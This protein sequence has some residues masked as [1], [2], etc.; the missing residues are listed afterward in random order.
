MSPWRTAHHGP[1]VSKQAS[2]VSSGSS[3][4]SI[5]DPAEG[6]TSSSMKSGTFSTS[7]ALSSMTPFSEEP[8]RAQTG[9]VLPVTSVTVVTRPDLE[10]ATRRE[11]QE[12]NKVLALAW[13][14]GMLPGVLAG[15][16]LT[17]SLWS[18]GT[19]ITKTTEGSPKS[20]VATSSTQSHTALPPPLSATT[21]AP[22][23]SRSPVPT[24]PTVSTPTTKLTV[25]IRPTPPTRPM[26]S[27]TSS[28][29]PT[30]PTRH[31]VTTRST[32]PTT[33][34]PQ[35]TV[36][37]ATF[38]PG[39]PRLASE[40]LN[41]TLTW[42][43]SPCADFFGFV[44]SHFVGPYTNVLSTAEEFLKSASKSLLF[45]IRVPPRNQ[46]ALEKAAGLFQACIQ[47][48]NNAT[49][50]EAAA[51]RSFLRPAR[52]DMSS[53]A[54]DPKFS[55]LEAMMQL[56]MEFGFPCLVC[57]GV[58]RTAYQPKKELEFV[59]TMV[60]SQ[61]QIHEE[62]EKWI[63][64]THQ[65]HSKTGG[66][67]KHYE[68]YLKF[69]DP[70]L[71][72]ANLTT[73]IIAA[74]KE[75]GAFLEL[76]RAN[77]KVSGKGVQISNLGT[78]TEPHVTKADWFR[79][80][81][82]FTNNFY[83]G[84]DEVILW[85]NATSVVVFLTDTSRFNREDTR[86]LLAWTVLRK[87]VVYTSAVAMKRLQEAPVEDFCM[88]TVSGVLD[89]AV[90]S[91][92]VSTYT[93]RRAFQ[94]A[95]TLALNMIK[96]LQYKMTHTPWIVP[97]VQN[98]TLKKARSMR[99]VMGY[100]KHLENTT[101]L[102]KFYATFPD[103]GP[104]FVTPYL[105]MHRHLT[106]Q[107]FSN[108]ETENFTTGHANAFYSAGQNSMTI[109]GGI[110]QPP[111]YFPDGTAALNYGG[112]GQVIGHEIMHAY[113]IDGI[114]YDDTAHSVK[115]GNTSTMREYERKVLC[116]RSSYEAA[117]R[118]ARQLTDATDSEGF[119]DY[120]GIQLAYAAYRS[121]PAAERDATLPDVNL[122][123]EQT[124]FVA[125]CLKWCDLIK[126]RKPGGRY[127]PGRSRCIVPLQNMP[128]FA[129]A[130]GCKAGDL[131]NPSKRCDFW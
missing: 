58:I 50:S 115:F 29:R 38:Y 34:V 25:P 37:R 92:Y 96:A 12:R 79:L 16:A 127:W 62:D 104:G 117:E 71:N 14:W 124:F 68:K 27:T 35:P 113:D 53:M 11:R 3:T 10:E 83:V 8:S 129:H 85:D 30:A 40:Y 57:F 75:F 110:V 60:L 97:P 59:D 78:Y 23:T 63:K 49:G 13:V 64:E 128:E 2:P 65:S 28:T 118:R 105:E 98:V 70:K 103:A 9:S 45:T 112:L 42:T 39:G 126:K 84:S 66:L 18:A 88:K 61:M 119:A 111:M 26:V 102:E 54:P 47:L 46:N 20:P 100:P 109:L 67:D 19:P 80:Y 4:M 48:A 74:E 15:A 76:V 93:P 77:D 125:H 130:F 123:A 122:S 56:S 95:T 72:F 121:L 82:K 106:S 52:L 21:P 108:N 114:T 5:M 17:Y 99:L 86:L 36:P 1:A 73:R 81:Q 43:I 91:R 32:V 89:A 116:L 94:A 7:T 6:L 44:C 101:E 33:P 90:S 22:A 69:Y 31:T 131:M 51:L 87:L 41:V 107:T 24:V 120:S 55:A